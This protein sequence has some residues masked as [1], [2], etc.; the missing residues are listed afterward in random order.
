MGV[1]LGL[2]SFSD[3]NM[4][5]VFLSLIAL[6]VIGLIGTISPGKPSIRSVILS[7]EAVIS[8]L[9]A[10]LIILMT[11]IILRDIVWVASIIIASAAP[12]I[13]L[14]YLKVSR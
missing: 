14:L 12:L 7:R 13:L 3:G 5:K 8:L 2:S 6:S 4:D 11:S 9:L 10:A 1:L